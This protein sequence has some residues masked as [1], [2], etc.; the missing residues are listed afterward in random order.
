MEIRLRHP[1]FWRWMKARNTGRIKPGDY[2]LLVVFGAGSRGRGYCKM[3][4][5]D[6][7]SGYPEIR[8]PEIRDIKVFLAPIH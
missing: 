3:V 4:I 2:L 8:L 1:L 6:R 7:K 5:G